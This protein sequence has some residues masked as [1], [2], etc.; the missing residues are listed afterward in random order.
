[1]NY[2]LEAVMRVDSLW[3]K[4]EGSDAPGKG[5]ASFVSI[6]LLLVLRLLNRPGE[7]VCC[8]ARHGEV[9]AYSIT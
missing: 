2:P 8:G 9:N 7:K 5:V 3:P 4:K 1:M 6:A